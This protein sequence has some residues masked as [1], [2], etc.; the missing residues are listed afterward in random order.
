[1]ARLVLMHHQFGIG[2]QLLPGLRIGQPRRVIRVHVGQ[3][4]PLDRRGIDAG[5]R[6]VLLQFAG[7]WQQIVAR[8]G[9]DQR[10]TAGAPR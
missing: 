7:G 3:Q 10:E 6:Q 5:G 8:A 2:E 1:M 9:F 4:H